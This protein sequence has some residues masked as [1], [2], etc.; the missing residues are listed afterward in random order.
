MARILCFW[1]VLFVSNSVLA[2]QRD[3]DQFFF[4]SLLGD[5]QAEAAEL[6]AQGKRGIVL[7][8]EMDECPFC[9]R[10]HSAILSSTEV[11]ERYRSTFGIYKIDVKSSNAVVHISGKGTTESSMARELNV[12]GTPTTIFFDLKGNELY[13]YVGPAKDIREFLLL[14]NYVSG[15]E[16]KT[17]SF[18]EFRREAK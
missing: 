8:F 9:T 15:G 7:V 6:D 11:Q 17:K 5:L 18:R 3:P 13:R 1:F 4:Q 10:M 16:F 2:E 14:A 12:R